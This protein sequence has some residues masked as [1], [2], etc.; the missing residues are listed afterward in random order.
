MWVLWCWCLFSRCN[1]FLSCNFSCLMHYVDCFS[2]VARWLVKF[3]PLVVIVAF[4]VRITAIFSVWIWCEYII[5]GSNLL[6]AA[7]LS[8]LQECSL[9][10]CRLV[11]V[12]SRAS[13]QSIPLE[14]V[15]WV[16]RGIYWATF[17]D[18]SSCFGRCSSIRRILL[19][20]LTRVW[21]HCC[22]HSLLYRNLLVADRRV[23]R[24]ILISDFRVWSSTTTQWFPVDD[25][26]RNSRNVDIL[27]GR[28]HLSRHISCWLHWAFRSTLAFFSPIRSDNALTV[29]FFRKRLHLG[30]VS[31]FQ[32]IQ[33]FDLFF[34]GSSFLSL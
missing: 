12:R 11:H 26:I 19:E 22:L 2:K 18:Y 15:R 28:R 16:G 1:P 25:N 24:Y 32:L 8:T 9:F 7:M 27:H 13:S 20:K 34:R 31:A 14:F 6:S 29:Q 10:V 3:N 23:S 21:C 30:K 5:T 33:T 17:V 4:F